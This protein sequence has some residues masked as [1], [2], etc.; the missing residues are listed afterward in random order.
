MKNHEDELQ[1]L[2][3]F[4]GKQMKIMQDIMTDKTLYEYASFYKAS[5]NHVFRTDDLI[6][7]DDNGHINLM[8]NHATHKIIG[9]Y[10]TIGCEQMEFVLLDIITN[11]LF[12]LKL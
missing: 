12:T 4:L 9:L 8:M 2:S 5:M 11:E 7:V 6:G 10:G 3:N 1:N